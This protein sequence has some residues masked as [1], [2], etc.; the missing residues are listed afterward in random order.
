[1]LD[2][3]KSQGCDVA[4]VGHHDSQNNDIQWRISFPG[5]TSLL[6]DLTDVQILCY[7]L[8]KL[9]LKEAW[10]TSQ[11][12]VV[13]SFHIKHVMFWCVERFS[14]QWVDSDY[15]NCLNICL[16]KLIEMIKD[17]HIP[18]YIIERRNL[19]NSKMTETMSME[20]V[21]VLSKYDT[22]HV[23]TLKAFENV[24][25]LTQYDD[26]LLKHE[27]LTSTIRA[28]FNACITTFNFYVFNQ[29]PPWHL[30]IPHNATNSVLNYVKIQQ[31][32][33]QE[34]GVTIL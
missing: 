24:F 28:C 30:Y 9:I 7:G 18:P 14:C 22:T 27:T 34:K 3:I 19:F 16:T 15:I 29:S 11:R 17:R 1:M 12:E 21:D 20:I 6:L 10:N 5:E 8:I 26:V 2:N 32:L 23:S 31:K 33:K 13:S 25:Q 4:P